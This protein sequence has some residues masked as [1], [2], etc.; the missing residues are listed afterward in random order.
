MTTLLEEAFT[1]ASRLSSQEQDSLAALVLEEIDSERRWEELFA[2]SQDQ[3][4]DL[5]E[6]AL[7]EFKEGKTKSLEKESG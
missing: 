4:A 5:A 7:T 6:E 1:K 2:Q 3:L